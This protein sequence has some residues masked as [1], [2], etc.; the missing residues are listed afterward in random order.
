MYGPRMEGS[1]TLKQLLQ[2]LTH[3]S[4]NQKYIAGMFYQSVL[5]D[6][7]NYSLFEYQGISGL[8]EFMNLTS[9]SIVLHISTHRVIYREVIP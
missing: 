8:I 5:D 6:W 7:M 4:L 3:S 1:P 2:D 9:Y